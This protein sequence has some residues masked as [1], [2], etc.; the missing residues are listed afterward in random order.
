VNENRHTSNICRLCCIL[1]C[2]GTPSSDFVTCR[3]YFL[4]CEQGNLIKH[5]EQLIQ[6]SE[7]LKFLSQ[8]PEIMLDSPHFNGKWSTM[9]RFQNMEY[10][11][12]HLCHHH[13]WLSTAILLPLP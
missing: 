2:L 1:S 13:L 11:L 9:S 12:I 3:Q 4:Q 6:C 5:F 8:Q 10:P 7:R